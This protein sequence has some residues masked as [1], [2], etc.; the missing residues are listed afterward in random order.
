MEND[1]PIVLYLIVRE[2]LNM[3]CGKIGAQ[4]GHGVQHILIHYFRAQVLKVK[5][6]NDDKFPAEELE[7]IK[8]TTEWLS[9]SSTKIVK[10]ATDEEWVQIKEEYKDYDVVKDAGFTEVAPGSETLITL[11]PQ[12]KSKASQTIVEKLRLL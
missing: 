5:A 6:H 11:W 9:N 1:D 10:V 12:H 7:H 4:I 3:S 8:I 2:S